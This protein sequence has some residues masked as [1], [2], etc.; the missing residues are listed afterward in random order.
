[1]EKKVHK[2]KIK[3]KNCGIEFEH[4]FV[5]TD[6]FKPHIFNK[7]TMTCPSCGSTNF[8]PIRLDGK[9]SLEEWQAAHPDLN[10]KSLPDHSYLETGVA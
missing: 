5:A 8:D 7:L 9:E 10:I 2:W 4:I 3:C 1:M 6:L